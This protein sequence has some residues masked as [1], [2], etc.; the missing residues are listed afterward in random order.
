MMQPPLPHPRF[1]LL[2]L[3]LL[4]VLQVIDK[5]P[6]SSITFLLQ[7]YAIDIGNTCASKIVPVN[8]ESAIRRELAP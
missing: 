5:A 7:S 1:I 6:V 2:L 8:V 3:S 4:S